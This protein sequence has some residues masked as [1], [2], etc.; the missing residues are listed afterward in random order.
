LTFEVSL[1]RNKEE[2]LCCSS[3]G[4]RSIFWAWKMKQ[5]RKLR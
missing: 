2:H 3:W 4:F 5:N 1:W